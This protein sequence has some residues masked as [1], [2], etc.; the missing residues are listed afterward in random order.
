MTMTDEMKALYD[1]VR[2]KPEPPADCQ[3]CT[4]RHGGCAEFTALNHPERPYNRRYCGWFDPDG[5]SP[6]GKE[7]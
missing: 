2:P 4:R 5:Q 6:G 7:T 1:A 3:K